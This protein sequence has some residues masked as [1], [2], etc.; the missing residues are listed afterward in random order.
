MKNINKFN[1]YKKRFPFNSNKLEDEEK[2][3]KYDKEKDIYKQKAHINY[4]KDNFQYMN[5][6]IEEHFKRNLIQNDEEIKKFVKND[7]DKFQNQLIEDFT[8][9]KNKQKV[10]FERL[11]DNFFILNRKK[12]NMEKLNENDELKSEP[13]YKGEN[14][15]NIFMEMP[16]Y[17]YNLIINSPGDTKTELIN[18]GESNYYKN[19]LCYNIIQ[20]MGNTNLNNIKNFSPP[21]KQFIKVNNAKINID[22]YHKARKEFKEKKEKELEKNEKENEKINNETK[23]IDFQNKLFYIKYNNYKEEIKDLK[24]INEQTN[25]ILSDIKNK[26]TKDNFFNNDLTHKQLNILKKNEKEIK[27]ILSD[28]NNNFEYFDINK[29]YENENDNVEYLKKMNELK[30]KYEEDFNN[31]NNE[32]KNFRKKYNNKSKS[33][34][35]NKSSS[36]IKRKY[37]NDNPNHYHYNYDRASIEIKKKLNRYL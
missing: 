3:N 26:M 18:N 2:F 7:F 19:K 17:K 24:N 10:F 12:N 8:L 29:K 20:C 15:K 25:N 22:Y 9:F 34:K 31:L 27:D 1:D 30:E 11:Q 36:I 28:K 14:I 6:L 13:L 5:H 21:T 37:Y 23:N 35:R 16:Q 4:N 33:K 32:I